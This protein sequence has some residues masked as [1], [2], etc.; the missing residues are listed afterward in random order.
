MSGTVLFKSP[1]DHGVYVKVLLPDH[2]DEKD[3][4]KVDQLALQVYE[5]ANGTGPSKFEDFP[6]DRIGIVALIIAQQCCR[7]QKEWANVTDMARAV[8][9]AMY[10][11]G[12]IEGKEISMTEGCRRFIH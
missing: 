6:L 3:Y 5:I 8:L 4:R 9:L 1:R 12:S 11:D 10:P 2:F 7:D